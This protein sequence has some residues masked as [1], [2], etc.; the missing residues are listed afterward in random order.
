[1]LTPCHVISWAS[2]TDSFSLYINKHIYIYAYNYYMPVSGPQVCA[3]VFERET[4]RNRACQWGVMTFK[5]HLSLPLWSPCTQGSG[6][7]KHTLPTA[8][9]GTKTHIYTH[10]HSPE[11]WL[12][13]SSLKQQRCLER[14][15]DRRCLCFSSILWANVCA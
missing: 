1:M 10:K 14:D 4:D 8:A 11:T 12:I 3:R 6:L 7:S 5:H 2:D 13:Q 9:Q 15:R